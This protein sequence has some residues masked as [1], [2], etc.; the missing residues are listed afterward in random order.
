M[1]LSD[2]AKCMDAMTERMDVM[3]RAMQKIV[4]DSAENA[5]HGGADYLARRDI[6][7]L[8]NSVGALEAQADEMQQWLKENDDKL[9]DYGGQVEDLA[10]RVGGVTSDGGIDGLAGVMEALEATVSEMKSEIR[11]IQGQNKHAVAEFE[12]IAQQQRQRRTSDDEAVQA[13]LAKLKEELTAVQEG[14]RRTEEQASRALKASEEAAEG[15]S[16]PYH[17]KSVLSAEQMLRALPQVPPAGDCSDRVAVS[18]EELQQVKQKADKTYER[19]AVVRED[20]DHVKGAMMKVQE[21]MDGTKH[22]W[23]KVTGR[24]D[25]LHLEHKI[26]HG[27]LSELNAAIEQLKSAGPSEQATLVLAEQASRDVA[28][29]IAKSTAREVAREVAKETAM[30]VG[31][32]AAQAAVQESAGAREH[33]ISSLSTASTPK[34]KA[35]ADILER[36]YDVE[37]KVDLLED[38]VGD[39]AAGAKGYGLTAAEARGA[40]A[41]SGGSYSPPRTPDAAAGFLDCKQQYD[42]LMCAAGARTLLI[43]G[44]FHQYCVSYACVR[45]WS[46]S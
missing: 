30:L 31:A 26:V 24:V 34:A 15:S 21:C 39:V 42:T 37:R 6:E 29:E 41:S 10:A 43:A 8:A 4:D 33:D 13:S 7:K 9:G 35:S 11:A 20:I 25:D 14:Q 38:R 22:D 2:F 3:D 36:L 23:E 27:Q 19:V 18:V 1:E 12:S 5:H 46:M 40:G 44:L 17:V 45:L 28:I 16:A 32:E